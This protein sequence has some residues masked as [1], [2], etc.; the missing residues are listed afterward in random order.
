MPLS[1]NLITC[2]LAMAFISHAKA[3]QSNDNSSQRLFTILSHA[4]VIDN[5]AA[6]ASPPFA[7]NIKAV[8]DFAKSFKDV[9]NV[10]WYT[11]PDGAMVYF[12]ERGIK[13][14]AGY[15]KK[16]NWLYCMRSYAEQHLPKEIRAQV[17]SIYYDYAITWV[18]EI[19]YGR[20]ALYVVH[21]QD[22]FCWKNIRISE[23]EMETMETFEKE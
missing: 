14:R 1:P 17:K 12:T 4:T 19:T 15:D 11:V 18:N 21:I 13:S 8:R 16:G 2:I 6:A 10:H 5:A 23:D 3:Q 20:Q 22:E 7:V 9:E